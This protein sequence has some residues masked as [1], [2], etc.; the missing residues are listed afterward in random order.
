MHV[1]LGVAYPL[2]FQQNDQGLLCACATAQG[3][4]D[5]K[6]HYRNL[7]L[8]KKILPPLLPRL[9]LFNLS[10]TSLA[11]YQQA[12]LA[13]PDGRSCKLLFADSH[14]FHCHH[15]ISVLLVDQHLSHTLLQRT[16]QRIVVGQLDQ[17]L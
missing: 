5:T 11:L 8:E 3:G 7:T 13:L 12:I 4:T 1:F 15:H 2:H 14:L 16:L 10:I 9:D 17:T 6:S